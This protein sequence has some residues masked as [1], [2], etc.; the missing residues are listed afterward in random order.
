[1]ASITNDASRAVISL[2]PAH[3]V[4]SIN[5]NI[6]SAFTEHMGR[7]IYGG[8]YDPQ[9]PNKD[10]VTPEGFRK[11][12]IDTLRPL[13]TPLCAIS[14][15]QLCDDLSLGRWCRSEGPP[16]RQIRPELGVR[17]NESLRYG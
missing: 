10:L 3:R 8:I 9:N 4:A 1:M 2:N 13:N 15:R 7:C 14:W 5:R 12:V 11:D 6:F 16:T 17:R